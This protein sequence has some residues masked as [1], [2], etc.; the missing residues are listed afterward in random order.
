MGL[1]SLCVYCFHVFPLL[2]EII[3]E[4]SRVLSRDLGYLSF[5]R[6]EVGEI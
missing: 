5:A 2:S 4:G 1:D 6:F 3:G